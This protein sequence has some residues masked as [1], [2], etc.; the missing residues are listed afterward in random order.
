MEIK[1]V[2]EDVK[3][4]VGNKG[5]ILIGGGL[6]LLF[7]L[8]YNR[9]TQNA[10]QQ[11]SVVT[12]VTSYPDV[13]TNA[14]VVIESIQN[15]IDYSER[16]IIET[17]G[18]QMDANNEFLNTNFEE[19]MNYIQDGFDAQLEMNEMNHDSIMGSLDDVQS[20]INSSINHTNEIKQAVENAVNNLAN[21]V[22]VSTPT[23]STPTSTQTTTP[24]PTTT[25]PTSS[26]TQYYTYVTKAGLNT[27][28][29][30]VDALKATGEDSSMAHRKEIAA[31]N[32]IN[33]YTGTATQNLVMLRRLKNGTLKK[34]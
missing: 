2:F 30:I 19:M 3:D 23:T 31:A 5:L 32:G 18:G 6:A 27:S 16:E 14:N 7:I 15:S 24:K 13:V 10:G 17:I 22:P 12:G 1:E 25:T 26:G 8:S 9:Q 4:A 34:A 21:K 11:M 33:N 28:T 20:A 29:S